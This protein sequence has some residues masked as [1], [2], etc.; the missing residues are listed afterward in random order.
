LEVLGP[1]LEARDAM[2]F[3]KSLEM[4]VLETLFGMECEGVSI[5]TQ[6]LAVIPG[7]CKTSGQTGE[8]IYAYADGMPFN[9]GSTKQLAEV[10]FDQLGSR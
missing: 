9:I 10:L 4:P 6:E 2:K 5:D 8:D 3:F 1:E 7:I